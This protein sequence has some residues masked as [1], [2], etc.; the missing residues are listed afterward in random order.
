[1][2]FHDEELSVLEKG[3][4]IIGVDEV[5]RGS[6]AGP[7]CASAC[8]ITPT[9]FN[10]FEFRDTQKTPIRDSKKLSHAQRERTFLWLKDNLQATCIQIEALEIDAYGIQKANEKALNMALEQA[11]Y[12]VQSEN[13]VAFVDH[14]KISPP[15]KVSRIISS[16]HGDSLYMSVACA[17]IWAKETRDIH[18][19]ELADDHP[20]YGW[21]SNS[22]YGTLNHREAIIKHGVSPQH[23]MSF[24]TKMQ[25]SYSKVA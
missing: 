21:E 6:L 23:R 2:D 19:A 16:T 14:F 22:G 10:A 12:N 20:H 17:S 8:I 24:L 5:G 7:I 3:G 9:S 15:L 4:V 25:S 18:M 13:I 11:S 1:M